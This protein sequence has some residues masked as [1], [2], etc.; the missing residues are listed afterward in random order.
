MHKRL[1][2]FY[3]ALLLTGVNL[4]LRLVSTSFQVY[5]SG[6]IGAEGIGLLQLVMSV[7]SMAMTA[8]MAGIRTAT[9]YLT[10]EALGRKQHKTIGWVLSACIRYSLVCSCALSALLYYAAPWIAES[11]IG[12]TQIIGAVRL[13]AAFLPVVCLCGVMSGYFT[14]ANRIRS[15]A[16]VEI[17][18]Q[19][20][21]MGITILALSFWAGNSPARAC[22]SVV[23]G[24][25]AGAC[26]TL[27]C[28]VVLRLKE[29]SYG[30][31]K[32]P[33]TRKLLDTAVPL[34]FADDLKAGI[35]TTENM[36][37]PKRLSLYAG[38][39]SPLAEF[40]TVCG[41]VFPVMMFPAAILFGLNELLIPELARC[42]ASG[43]RSRIQYLVQRSLRVAM[44]Y[45]IFFCG[46]LVLLADELCMA[47]YGN[48]DAGRYLKQFSLMVPMLYCDA[49][50]DA[51]T[52]GLGQQKLCV[53]YNILTSA[54]DVIFLYLLLP[55]FG[56]QGYFLSF[57]ATHLLNFI[58]SLRRL[59][60]ITGR[61]MQWK[62]PLASIVI[63]FAAIW[64]ASHITAPVLRAITYP[65]LLGSSLFLLGI[66]KKEDLNWL[67][68]LLQQK[69][70]SH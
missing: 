28:L 15:L 11:W 20:F 60:I 24:S 22:Q 37:V 55:K 50:T 18:E 27:I 10:A 31:E 49:V 12:N 52:K 63:M 56:M 21:S 40:G 36:M 69:E 51:M 13:F 14:A 70:R 57:L 44:L 53:R 3:N 23:I 38:S 46:M 9:M 59:L 68:S 16:A 43:S 17:A 41:M 47:L 5:L 54:L 29:Q 34:A 6:R 35:S 39:G 45:G 8:G 25:S 61:Q 2:I 66:V 19:F 65:V 64:G 1:P 48:S 33:V 67:L 4:L 62:I 32:V 58:L 26:L 30:C 42:N 7:G